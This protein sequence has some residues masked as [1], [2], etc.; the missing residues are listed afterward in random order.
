[1]GSVEIIDFPGLRVIFFHFCK[2]VL[3]FFGD[4]QNVMGDCSELHEP[5]SKILSVLESPGPPLSN[6]TENESNVTK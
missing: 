5:I 1:M 3:F 4:E 2:G 6:G